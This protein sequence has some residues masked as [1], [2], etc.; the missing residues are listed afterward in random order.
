VSPAAQSS[1][2]PSQPSG[3]IRVKVRGFAGR[4]LAVKRTP[5]GIVIETSSP[6]G[7]FAKTPD[8][9]FTSESLHLDIPVS[10][11]EATFYYQDS[12]EGK[13]KLSARVR[14]RLWKMGRQ[15]ATIAK[16]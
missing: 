8:G 13:L 5:M 3:L 14:G 12:T 11:S 7:K 6:T 10:Q 9:P 1:L 2:A 4:Y 15:K 16:Q